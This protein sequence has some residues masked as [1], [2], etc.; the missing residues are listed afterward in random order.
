MNMCNMEQETKT[1]PAVEVWRP[2]RDFEGLY[3]VSNLAR[4]RS[5]DIKTYQR[6]PSGVFSY[7]TRK[8]VMKKQY[9][10]RGYLSV[11]LNKDGVGFTKF[12]HRLVAEAFV[13]NPDNLPEV[14]H[15]DED[16]TNNL[17]RNLE[18]CTNLYNVNYGTGKYRKTENYRK[19]IEQLTLD[20]QHV[21]YFESA[22][23]C[24]RVT[25]YKQAALW[26]ALNG[27]TKTAYGYQWR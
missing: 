6:F 12:V 17:P 26:Q 15:K 13:P 24:A 11:R 21:A 20:G 25:T 3:E 9:I 1:T 8:G 27:K 19:Q 22:R 10:N 7:V 5:L 16:R 14:N 4:V 2:V 18:W 23:Q